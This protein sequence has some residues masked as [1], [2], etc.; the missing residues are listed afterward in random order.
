MAGIMTHLHFNKNIAKKID[1]IDKGIFIISGYGPDV[2]YFS[3][4]KKVRKLGHILH[5]EN[6]RF[7]FEKLMFEIENLN[8]D[9]VVYYS[10]LKGMISHFALDSVVHPFVFYKTGVYKKKDN[11]T[12]KYKSQ[13][14]KMESSIDKLFLKKILKD[15]FIFYDTKLRNFLNMFFEKYYNLK[16]V[17]DEYFR[18]LKIMYLNYKFLRFDKYGVKYK[19]Y[20]LFTFL[21]KNLKNL[22]YYNLDCYPYLNIEKSVWYNPCD[23]SI[24]EE[25][26]FFDLYFVAFHKAIDLINEKN[27]LDESYTKGINYRKKMKYFEF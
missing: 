8:D 4:N 18:A 27:F 6:S 25:K 26:S 3:F 22:S 21:D 10:F 14:R 12:Y 23:I 19:F 1:N 15:E 16:N 7:F 24:K 9:D 20:S 5:N 13:H 17:G 2:F 11:S